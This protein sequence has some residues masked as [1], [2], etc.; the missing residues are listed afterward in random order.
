MS[1]IVVILRVA[2]WIIGLGFL[3]NSY[4]DAHLPTEGFMILWTLGAISAA[5]FGVMAM[6]G[7]MCAYPSPY[8]SWSSS[9]PGPWHGE[10]PF[11]L[12]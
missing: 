3:R 2:I 1:L 4:R 10:W 11:P 12:A 7:A 6:T 5:L 9:C 8:P